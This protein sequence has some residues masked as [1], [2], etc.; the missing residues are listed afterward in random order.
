MKPFCVM[1]R[2]PVG[3]QWCDAVMYFD[4]EL[5]L[6]SCNDTFRTVKWIKLKKDKNYGNGTKENTTK[7]ELDTG[8]DQPRA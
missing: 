1:V 3:S 2:S 4:G 5:F 7:K 6:R 8:G